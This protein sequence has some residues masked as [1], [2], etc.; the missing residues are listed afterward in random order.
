MFQPGLFNTRTQDLEEA[1]HDAAQFYWG[2]SSAWLAQ[3][4]VFMPWSAPV[5]L[6][7]YRVQDIDSPED[8]IRAEIICKMLRESEISY[9][10]LHDCPRNS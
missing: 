9:G 8:W 2:L 4:P 5:L 6:P 7:R 10:E 3:K 1:W